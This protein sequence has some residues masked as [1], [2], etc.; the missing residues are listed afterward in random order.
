[1]GPWTSCQAQSLLVRPSEPGPEGLSKHLLIEYVA[2]CTQDLKGSIFPK[3]GSGKSW[4]QRPPVFNRH[5]KGA[6]PPC[7]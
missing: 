1:M 3:V 4:S 2:E 7:G 6:N 5:S